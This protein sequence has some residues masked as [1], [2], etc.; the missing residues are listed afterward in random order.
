MKSSGAHRLIDLGDILLT[1]IFQT[2][3]LNNEAVDMCEVNSV[4]FIE[5]VKVKS[6]DVDVVSFSYVLNS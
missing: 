2:W 4:F 5:D 3:S 6:N 1:I